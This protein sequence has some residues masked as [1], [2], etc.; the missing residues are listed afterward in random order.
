MIHAERIREL[1]LEAIAEAEQSAPEDYGIHP[2]VGAVLADEHGQIISRAHR[3]ESGRGD[4][5][6]FLVLQKA[7]SLAPDL[8]RSALFVT[9][10]PCTA[11]GP[12]KIPCTQRILDSRIPTIYIGMLDP[13][14]Q[15]C[16]RGETF[17]R[18]NLI[19]ERFPSELVK[20][21]EGSNAAFIDQ[22]RSAHLPQ[23]SLYVTTQIA[24]LICDFLRRNGL[25]I[26][27]LPFDWDVTVDDLEQYCSSCLDPGFTGDLQGLLRMAR[28]HA[29]DVKY[30]DLTY[31]N[32]TRGLGDYW[33]QEVREIMR[34]LRADD[35]PQRRVINVGIG[36]GLEAKGLFDTMPHLT[37]IDIG[38]RS[39]ERAKARLPRA[40]VVLAEAENLK[41]VR[42][43][44][45]DIYVSL[46]TYQSSY[47]DIMRAVGEAYR[48][49]RQG[50]LILISIANGFLG[51][52][53]ALIPGLVIP[54]TNAVNRDRPF[55]VA[56]R[57]RRKVTLLRFE[58]VG[59]R[60]GLAEIY[61]YGR[62]G[63]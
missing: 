23:S 5:A 19:V 29:F 14:P 63:R 18:W 51:E 27:E 58:E 17:L 13:N 2:K 11:R 36:N 50:G 4:H 21:I 47:F 48:V 26:D 56:E 45:Q 52:D 44:S 37:A 10:E 53:S 40:K 9:L 16:G 42:T 54:R 60:T 6:E 59:V 24:D 25:D 41:G 39:L 49:V 46:R 43:A 38:P 62:R 22:H 34:L 30:A 61:V 57:I 3:G 1:M 32:D 20:K 15:I 33:Q 8:A 55:E 31:D 28:G 7:E 12:G 35:Y